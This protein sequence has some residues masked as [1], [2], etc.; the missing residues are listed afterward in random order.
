MRLWRPSVL[1]SFLAAWV[2]FGAPIYAQPDDLAALNREVKQLY[3]AGKHAEALPIAHRAL[4]VAERR[5]GRE[6][7]AVGNALNELALLHKSR[8]QYSEAEPLYQRNIAILEKVRGADHAELS[9]PLNNLAE[10]Y[11]AQGR[12]AEGEPLLKRAIANLE[13]TFGSE[14]LEVAYPINNLGQLYEDQGREAEAEPLY[15]RSLALREKHLAPDHAAI[16][17]T[18]NNLSALYR[19]QHRFAEA[20]PLQIRALAIREKSLG[21]DHPLVGQS[22][23]NL[24]LIYATQGRDAEAEPLYKRGHAIIEKAMG[25][26]H[27]DVIVS[28]SNHAHFL[29]FRWR[30]AEAEPLMRRAMDIAERTLGPD[31]PLLGSTLHSLALLSA[32]LGRRA[33]VEPLMQRALAVLE[34]TLGADHPDLVRLLSNLGTH[35]YFQGDWE[36]ALGTLTRGAD[37]AMRRSRQGQQGGFESHAGQSG[38]AARASFAFPNLARVHYRLAEQTPARAPEQLR[39]AFVVA[40]WARGSDAAA[41]LAQMAVREAKGDTA[42]ARIVR[43]RQDLVGEWQA[44]DKLLIAAVSQPPERRSS[45]GEAAERARLTAIDARLRDIDRTLA[46]DFPEYAALTNPEPLSIAET[47]AQ[48]GAGEALVLFLEAPAVGPVPEAGFVWAVTR[49]DAR[50]ARIERGQKWLATRVQ[51]LRCGLDRAAW[52]GDGAARCATLLG[53]SYTDADINTGRLPPFDLARAHELY[54]VLFGKVEDLIKDKHLLLVPSGPLTALP[55]QVLVT[56][57]PAADIPPDARGY[58]SAAW[59]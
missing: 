46:A 40:Q 19:K 44:R 55:F 2:A 32:D 5:F 22:V 17:V 18:L 51:A 49:T 10:L 8:G 21:P 58:A 43:E 26:N 9:P 20:E 54:S 35:Y 29:R 37:I 48:L 31:H 25:P 23:G 34:K 39:A 7:P 50:W 24:A 28:L 33:N 6:H 12:Y 47:Q 3:Q 59:L 4:E 16:A 13:A 41:S 11:R 27:R 53:Q 45:P 30:A 36:R 38:E 15:K 1:V 14:R 42:L 57:R 52:S 56:D